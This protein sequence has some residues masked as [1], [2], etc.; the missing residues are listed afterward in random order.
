MKIILLGA[1]GA[2]KGTLAAKV[3]EDLQVPH[4]STGD[5]FRQAIADKT[6]LGTRI[7]EI[8]N[9]GKLV[10][11]TLTNELV[12]ERILN[13]DCANGYIL[14]GY[15]RT[16]A[17]AEFLDGI[18]SIT[19]AVL[20]DI[21]NDILVKRLS[22]RRTC[23]KCKESYNVHTNAPKNEGVCDKCGTALTQ[24]D[25]DTEQTALNRISVYEKNT[26][27][28]I[29]YYKTHKKLVKIKA[30]KEIQEVRNDFLKV[31]GA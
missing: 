13:M 29:K 5:M 18:D 6:E 22:G 20:L 28:L 11:D 24:R 25:D 3:K 26:K 23:P 14:D 4:I 9:E 10:P 12:E 16:V 7:T 19:H 21:N 1:P 27:P 31:I 30:D 17:Q 2:G 8:M 15:P